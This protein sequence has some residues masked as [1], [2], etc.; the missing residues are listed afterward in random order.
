MEVFNL[1]I[2]VKKQLIKTGLTMFFLLI[3]NGF[4]NYGLSLE[5]VK[6]TGSSISFGLGLIIG[7]LV[8]FLLA[9]YISRIIDKYPKKN[10]AMTG[11]VL[12][13]CTYTLF[14]ILSAIERIN[15]FHI[16]IGYLILS[17]IFMRVFNLSFLSSNLN[18]VGEDNLERVNAVERGTASLVAIIQPAIGAILWSLYG[19]SALTMIA[20]ILSVIPIITVYLMNFNLFDHPFDNTQ[21]S[22]NQNQTFLTGLKIIHRNKQILG[23]L[24][25][26]SLLTIIVSG[27][28]V[29]YPLIVLK[30]LKFSA[31]NLGYG[32]TLIGICALIGSLIV[33]F[34][35]FKNPLSNLVKILICNSVLFIAVGITYMFT[36]NLMFVFLVVI[37]CGGICSIIDNIG[38]PI[39]YSYLQKNVKVNEVGLATTVYY[40]ILELSMPIGS[41]CASLLFDSIEISYI[42]FVFSLPLLYAA[43]YLNTKKKIV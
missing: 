7:P 22:D 30:D 17:G 9:T 36:D 28:K 2:K 18:L 19:I 27:Y 38:D 21:D 4:V 3:T 26:M 43:F 42:F 15:F 16:A 1:N 13:S 39:A 23:I 6:R 31:V 41:I 12:L 10:M 8:G 14:F 24:V 34:T 37:G 35:H 11:V 20:A 25:S 33:F 32:T 29:I 5:L 40:T